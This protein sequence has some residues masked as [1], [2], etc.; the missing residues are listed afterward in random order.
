MSWLLQVYLKLGETL[1][2]RY[3]NKY[4]RR[5]R[6]RIARN[7]GDDA[8]TDRSSVDEGPPEDVGDSDRSLRM[9]APSGLKGHSFATEGGGSP[10]NGREGKREGAKEADAESAWHCG[11]R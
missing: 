1:P 3:F 5:R 9:Q 2:D 7:A 6:K 11:R 10:G 4:R 8:T